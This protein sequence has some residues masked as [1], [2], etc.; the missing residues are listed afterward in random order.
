MIDRL[1][2]ES[3]DLLAIFDA[4]RYDVFERVHSEYVAGSLEQVRSPGTG[5]PEFLQSAF[6]E[7]MDDVVYVSANPFVSTTDSRLEEFDA[8]ELFHDVYELWDTDT[9][10]D[11]GAVPPITVTKAIER[12]TRKYPDKRIIAHYIQPHVPF[13]SHGKLNQPENFVLR[14]VDGDGVLA[15]RR[16]RLDN[17]LKGR[18]GKGRLWQLKRLLGLNA[19]EDMEVILQRGGHTAL[20][21]A[22]EHNLRCALY[23]VRDAIATVGGQS[24]LTADH[25]EL[26]GEENDFGHGLSRDHDVLRDVPWFT[27]DSEATAEIDPTPP[28]ERWVTKTS[29]ETVTDSV[30]SRLSDLGYVNR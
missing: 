19:A 21:G 25:G 10:P 27:V 3:W 17:K 14:D 18:L 11:L 23:S 29:G 9:D 16:N 22:Y 6:L 5:T 12:A 24:V 13:L 4:C 30:E 1:Y 15:Q 20:R 26:L 7:P 8:G 2:S 28:Q